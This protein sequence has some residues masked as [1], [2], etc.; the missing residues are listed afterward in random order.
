M[1]DYNCMYC[2]FEWEIEDEWQINIPKQKTTN[3]YETILNIVFMQ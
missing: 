1:S 2:M 3:Y